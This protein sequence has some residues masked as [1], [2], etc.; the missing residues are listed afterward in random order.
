MNCPQKINILSRLSRRVGGAQRNPP[1]GNKSATDKRT[2]LRQFVALWWLLFS[3]P[4]LKNVRQRYYVEP[5]AHPIRD[6]FR[7]LITTFREIRKYRSVFLFLV[8][9]FF[10][11]DGVNTIITMAT[12]YGRDIGLG[13][14]TLILAILM[15]QIV[16]FPFAL[17]Y[18]N[19][20]DRFSVR[21]MLYAGISV[22]AVITLLSFFIPALPTMQMKSTAFWILAFLVASSQG[23][24]QALSRSFFSQ[25][26]PKE[27]SAE[28]F[29]FYN[30]CVKFAAITGPFLMDIISRAT[31]DSR[32]GVLSILVLFIIGGTLLAKVRESHTQ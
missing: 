30:I 2:S 16:A 31:G 12:A 14:N 28:F 15:I 5:G 1:F 4:L 7:R 19:L 11:I 27:R 32:Y 9:Y 18:G 8:A 3:I 22:Y 21:T 24:I 10:Y 13:V 26:I 20:A 17:L 23:G 6:S 29:G 25:L